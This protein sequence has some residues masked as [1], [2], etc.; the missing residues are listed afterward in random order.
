VG[1]LFA[2]R[3]SLL[4]ID[5]PGVQV[6]VNRHL[7]AGHRIQCESGCDFRGA[8]CTVADD[9]VL[10]RNQCKK[11]N[12]AHHIIAA[13]HEL[14]EG[15]DDFSRCSRP[16]TAVQQDPA[17]AGQAQRQTKQGQQEQQTREHGKLHRLQNLDGDQHH[18]HRCGNA[19][20]QQKIKRHRG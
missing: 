17:T 12:K 13:Y 19:E 10:D 8:H 15:L 1:N 7:L 3:S 18:Q 5:Q 6:G 20:S 4:F 9:H 14:A 2:A 16:L 11:E